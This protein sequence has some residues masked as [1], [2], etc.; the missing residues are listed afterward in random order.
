MFKFKKKL[1]IADD[2]VDTSTAHFNNDNQPTNET[3]HNTDLNHFNQINTDTHNHNLNKELQTQTAPIKID[4]ENLEKNINDIQSIK[5]TEQ[6]TTNHLNAP[7]NINLYEDLEDDPLVTQTSGVFSKKT[8]IKTMAVVGS[9]F[10]LLGAFAKFAMSSKTQTTVEVAM[11][12]PNMVIDKTQIAVV[13]QQELTQRNAVDSK[14]ASQAQANG[15]S[16]MNKTVVTITQQDAQTQEAQMLAQQAMQQTT[17]QASTVAPPPVNLISTP[18]EQSGQA[19]LNDPNITKSVL[20]Q[21]DNVTSPSYSNGFTTTVYNTQNKENNKTFKAQNHLAANENA[22]A[23]NATNLIFRTGDVA[24]ASLNFSVNTDDGADD[25][26]ATLHGG[27]YDGSTLLGRVEVGHN[28][29]KVRFSSLTP[30]NKQQRTFAIDA[31]AIRE[32]DARRGMAEGI[33]NHTIERYSALFAA[34]VLKGGGAVLKTLA[35]SS[36]VVGSSILMQSEKPDA[37]AVAGGAVAELGQSL[38]QEVGRTFNRPPTY[39]IPAGQAF[40]LIFMR[41]IQASK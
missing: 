6:L 31:V 2:I 41:D 28:N 38:S 15:E 26:L 19:L 36:T 8:F 39:T 20:S 32:Q 5:K 35:S 17:A 30:K 12:K 23:D 37:K 24:Y 40:G 33:N 9:G 25:V 34:S 11:S 3:L 7:S 18:V 1:L 13:D 29:I 16:F 14:I 27:P 21:A 4:T 22:T 10:I